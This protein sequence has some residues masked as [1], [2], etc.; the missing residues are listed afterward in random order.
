M[1]TD[2]ASFPLSE[3]VRKVARYA[4]LF[5]PLRTLEKVRAHRHMHSAGPPL[6]QRWSNPAASD[7]DSADVAI[8]GCGSF[9]Y[10]NIA[11]FCSRARRHFL[12]GC[13][14]PVG[15]RSI[16][17]CARYGGQYAAVDPGEL[18]HDPRIRLVFI[19]SNHASHAE[20]AI[21]ALRAGKDV[22][23]EKPHVV[24]EDQL[25]RLTAAMQ[26]APNG[27]VYLGFNRPRSPHVA[28]IRRWLDA[29]S[30]PLM[31][32]WFIAGHAMPEDHWYFSPSEGGRILG[33]LCHW[34][35]L[36][37]ELVGHDRAFPVRVQTATHH[38]SK[39]D[40]AVSFDFADGSVAAITFSAKGETFE[41]VRE[42]L[43]IHRGNSLISMR[44]FQV[45]TLNRGARRETFRTAFR[46]HGHGATIRNTLSGGPAVT[47]ARVI[48]SARLFLG[49]RRAAE[50]FEIV[51]LPASHLV[52]DVRE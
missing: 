31:I 19:A 50:H 33:N 49:A 32:N 42:Y 17:L 20:Y 41:G 22:H 48:D 38:R 24:N 27:R 51:E 35:D 44:D 21:A 26:A 9:S 13:Y 34:T 45:S 52:R 7:D 14:D 15:S 28:R 29:E 4:R 5:G 6:A 18:L 43:N 2:Y 16:S 1:I 3:R 36:S 8:I 47:R 11:Y 30:G 12:R 23:V 10:S 40:F 37:L 46:N 25:D 39:S